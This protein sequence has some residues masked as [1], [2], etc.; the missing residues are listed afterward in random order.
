LRRC[1]ASSCASSS[2][3]A[4]RAVRAADPSLGATAFDRGSFG[5]VGRRGSS[6][7]SVV[8][9]RRPQTPCA[10]R[11]REPDH[12]VTTSDVPRR[13]PVRRAGSPRSRDRDTLARLSSGQVAVP[14]RAR[15]RT[16]PRRFKT[17]A[18]RARDA[19]RRIEFESCDPSRR[20]PAIVD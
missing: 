15:A 16:H 5:P 13:T 4:G 10:L 18:P 3:V 11:L 12:P 8:L 19:F 9:R 7:N 2:R 14:R 20:V 17:R 6:E 1:A